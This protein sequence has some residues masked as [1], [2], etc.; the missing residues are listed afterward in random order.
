MSYSK[1][2]EVSRAALKNSIQLK[3]DEKVVIVSNPGYDVEKIARSLYEAADEL[4]GIPVLIFQRKKSQLDYAE[5][6]ALEALNWA[7]V[8]LSIS[9]DKLGRDPAVGK[10]GYRMGDLTI[11]HRFDYLKELKK[12]RGAWT[13]TITEEIYLQ[14][15]DVD[16]QEMH[17][18]CKEITERLEDSEKIRVTSRSGTDITFSVEGQKLLIDDGLFNEP[19]K[20]GNW[21]AG[22]V[23]VAPSLNTADGTVV[24]DGS[25]DVLGE[26]LFVEEQPVKVKIEDG[27]VA[28]I[29]G[30]DAARRLENDIHQAMQKAREM[31]RNEEYVKDSKL[32]GEFGI[33]TN[34]N[35]K[36]HGNMLV[37]EKVRGTCHFAIGSNLP[38]GGKRD[39]INHFDGLVHNPTIMYNS[40]IL[41]K[42]GK[43]LSKS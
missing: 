4:G 16:Y 28:R 7:D 8:V 37:D 26:T 2:V 10:E 38:I 11:Y 39:A 22:E 29:S 1:L 27:Y 35:A 36:I 42:D 12:F 23:A 15:V 40:S 31:E 18:Y 34:K 17:R 25:L 33:G 5:L 24:F 6:P 9:K 3:P 19:G 32:L 14:C 41:M 43:L 13:P 21:P 20:G 30:Y